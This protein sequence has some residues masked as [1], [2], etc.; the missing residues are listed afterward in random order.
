MTSSITPGSRRHVSPLIAKLRR[1]LPGVVLA[2]ITTAPTV[3]LVVASSL[4][5]QEEYL[6]FHSRRSPKPS[7][8]PSCTAMT[9]PAFDKLLSVLRVEFS[10][11]FPV[12][13]LRMCDVKSFRSSTTTI[14]HLSRRYYVTVPA[15]HTLD[16]RSLPP[17]LGHEIHHVVQYFR[18][19]S[20]DHILSHYGGSIRSAE[21]A[22]DFGAGYILSKTDLS[23]L[24]EMNPALSG[25]FSTAGPDH[26]GTP[27]ARTVAFRSGLF[28]TR[29]V[30]KAYGLED[31]ERY[32]LSTE[33]RE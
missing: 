29:R 7:G 32:F 8:V 15:S 5:A 14:P 25:D 13:R 26:H 12:P 19:G 16:A 21:L 30:S 28:F 11:K 27:S 9:H 18:H 20:R 1:N 10:G 4:F 17:V 24:Y 23:T 2:S 6:G 3:I 33:L 31:A 22:A